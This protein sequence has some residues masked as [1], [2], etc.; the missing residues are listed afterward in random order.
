MESQRTFNPFEVNI[1][2]VTSYTD[3]GDDSQNNVLRDSLGVPKPISLT[4]V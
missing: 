2:S 1:S 4:K 3:E